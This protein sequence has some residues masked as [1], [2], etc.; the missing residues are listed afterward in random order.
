VVIQLNLQD[1][2]VLFIGTKMPQILLLVYNTIGYIQLLIIDVIIVMVEV[3][4]ML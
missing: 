3:L 4:L 1:L 2:L